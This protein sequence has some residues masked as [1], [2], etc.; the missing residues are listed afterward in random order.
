MR[1]KIFLKNAIL[2]L[3][4]IITLILIFPTNLAEALSFDD[5]AMTYNNV[6]DGPK[7]TENEKIIIKNTIII[8]MAFIMNILFI[9]IT[10]YLILKFGKDQNEDLKPVINLFFYI[11]MVS[12]FFSLQRNAVV[13]LFWFIYV[14]LICFIKCDKNDD[15]NSI[16]AIRYN[17]KWYLVVYTCMLIIYVPKLYD[18]PD[19]TYLKVIEG[20]IYG[21][22]I[23]IIKINTLKKENSLGNL[24]LLGVTVIVLM[25]IKI[26]AMG[27]NLRIIA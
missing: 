17:I 24:L 27:D 19:I 14:I 16:N 10:I 26:V 12:V 22:Q 4:L 11:S 9:F 13:S 21:L 2:I 1:K 5:S 18:S 23:F 7:T 15:V 20:L 3:L 6:I 8:I 25:F